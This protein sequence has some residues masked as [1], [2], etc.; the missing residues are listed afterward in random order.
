MARK[1]EK[2]E[3]SELEKALAAQLARPEVLSS[4]ALAGLVYYRAN[5]VHS[6]ISKAHAWYN[7]MA[8]YTAPESGWDAF[9]KA[10]L[11]A[12]VPIVGA[13]DWINSIEHAQK[14]IEIVEKQ[15]LAAKATYAEE[16]RRHDEFVKLG[17]PKPPLW[18]LTEFAWYVIG[19]TPEE[20]AK[21]DIKKWEEVSKLYPVWYANQVKLIDRWG[22]WANWVDNGPPPMPEEL[23]LWYATKAGPTQKDALTY[24]LAAFIVGMN[25]QLIPETIKGFGQVLQGVGEVVPL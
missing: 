16:K 25:P 23:R 10:V 13:V 4:L 9:K 11:G 6:G 3:K 1:K 12:A 19:M 21:G 15:W 2:K 22:Y 18:N 14:H 17:T 20:I 5:D 8:N 24:A 7:K